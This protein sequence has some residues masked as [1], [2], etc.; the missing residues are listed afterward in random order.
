M[1]R[2]LALGFLGVL[3]AGGVGYLASSDKPGRV[4]P[5]RLRDSRGRIGR[6][7]V[8]RSVAG[9]VPVAAPAGTQPDAPN[10][11]ATAPWTTLQSGVAAPTVTND[12]ATGPDCVANSATTIALP[13]VG[14]GQFS[15]VY[16]PNGC[17]TPAG[18]IDQSVYVKGISGGSTISIC[19][20]AITPSCV[21]CTFTTAG[22]TKCLR[23]NV[24]TGATGDFFIGYVTTETGG[25]GG[26]A[27]TFAAWGADCVEH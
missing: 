9:C 24:N 21:D 23:P 12:A 25:V 4:G 13:T 7:G 16:Q 6:E 17:E 27:V 20:F 15:G 1:R 10:D 5:G 14:G 18:N 26:S 22:F 2:R 8:T 3:L 19:T 11:F